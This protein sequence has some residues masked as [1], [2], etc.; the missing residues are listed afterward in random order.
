MTAPLVERMQLML[1]MHR[2]INY[3]FK[4]Y[5]FHISQNYDI[6]THTHVC[7]PLC[8]AACNQP[9][10]KLQ[11]S[12]RCWTNSAK[13]RSEIGA[14]W[15]AYHMPRGPVGPASRW[16]AMS[17]VEVGQ[18]TYPVHGGRVGMEGREESEGQ[19]HMGGRR[20]GTGQGAQGL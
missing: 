5:C 15:A 14:D 3:S 11:K 18:M 17:H 6:H 16:A 19:S 10:T 12:R 9:H 20:S 4:I 8:N 13:Q 7:A 1:H 2:I